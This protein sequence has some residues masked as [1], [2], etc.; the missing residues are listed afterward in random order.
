MPALSNARHE[1]FARALAAGKTQ[2]EAYAL[3]GFKPNSGN[4][5]PLAQHPDLGARV[6]EL[7]AE[8]DEMARKAIELAAERLSID[9]EWVMARLVENVNRAMQATAVE[10]DGLATGEY[11]Y[12]GSVAN[13][14]LELLGKELGI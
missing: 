9:R 10:R 8:Q 14:A 3:A 4:A 7:Q 11:R 1:A 6:A 12:D 2:L 13:R 5:S